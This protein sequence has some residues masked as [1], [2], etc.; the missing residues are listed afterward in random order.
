MELYNCIVGKTSEMGEKNDC[1][2]KALAIACNMSYEE[3]HALCARHGRKPRRGMKTKQIIEA[4]A[5][6]GYVLERII[7]QQFIQ[8]YPGVHK[9]LKCI[10]THHPVRF[11]N[12]WAH[13]ATYLAF[14]TSHV[15]AIVDGK[16]QD[17]TA[18][19]ANK[20]I[21]IYRVEKPL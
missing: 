15:L 9:G 7:P 18:Q 20:L 2:V 21:S 3:A 12:V 19:R 10:T 11:P 17:W 13:K 8:Q 14:Q 6:A 1:S 16:V 5:E 4:V